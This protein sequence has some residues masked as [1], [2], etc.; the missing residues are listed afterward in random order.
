MKIIVCETFNHLQ[1]APGCHAE[2]RAVVGFRSFSGVERLG[3][4]RPE[5]YTR[6]QIIDASECINHAL[7]SHMSKVSLEMFDCGSST[8]VYCRPW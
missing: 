1:N 4:Y 6:M 8:E 5:V 7:L 3:G 2:S